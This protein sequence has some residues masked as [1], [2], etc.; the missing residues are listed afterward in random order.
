MSDQKRWSAYRPLLIGFL[1]VLVLVGGLGSWS[2]LSRITGAVI[3]QGQIEVETNR[4]VV[5]H[6]D[7]GIVAEIIVTEGDTVEQG[8]VL[9]RLDAETLTSDLAVVEGQ[10]FEVL[11]RRARFEAERDDLPE[12]VFPE[13]LT[14]SGNPV[15]PELIEGQ[16]RLFETRIIT[17]EQ[18]KEQLSRRRDQ[19]TNQ[20]EGIEA[21]RIAVTETLSLL[22]EELEAQQSL[23]DR[24]LAQSARVLALRREAANLRRSRRRRAATAA[25]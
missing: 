25:G 13:I 22:E 7:G 12:I 10:L 24:G 3:A 1:G 11:A 16:M 20:I 21:Q 8:E 17:E 2:V 23:L 19:I 9:I 5:Q 4:Q 14:E 15:V 6:P 18:E